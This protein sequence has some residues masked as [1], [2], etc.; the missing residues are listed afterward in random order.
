MIEPILNALIQLFALISDVRD[1]SE[2]SSRERDIVRLFLTRQLN[3]EL[4]NRY[5]EMFDEYLIQYNAEK[6]DKGSIRDKKRTSLT[7]VKILGICDKING[8]LQ[9]K[10]KL[11]VRKDIFFST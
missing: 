1:I 8:E 9:Q 5:M 11:Y 2:I 7:A 10:Q 3:N 6:V 4:V